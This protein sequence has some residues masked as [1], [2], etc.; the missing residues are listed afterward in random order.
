METK[1]LLSQMGQKLYTIFTRKTSV[2]N[3]RDFQQ[4]QIHAEHLQKMLQLD[5]SID[6]QWQLTEPSK[7][8]SYA[9]NV[10]TPRKHIIVVLNGY[11][12]TSIRPVSIE[13]LHVEN[14]SIM[15]STSKLKG[16]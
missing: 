2:G 6:Y 9:V 16:M 10:R 12:K 1:L 7:I 4:E 13:D 14:C 8:F 11:K 3:S 15:N 5:S